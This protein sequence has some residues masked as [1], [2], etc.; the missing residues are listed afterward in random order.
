MKIT[1]LAAARDD[2]IDGFRFYEEGEEGLGSYFLSTLYADIESLRSLGGVHRK[3][4]KNYHRAFS[5]RFPF[6]IYYLLDGDSILVKAVIDCRR[7]P[8]WIRGHLRRAED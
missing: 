7:D 5:A 2:L 6:A 3:V 8:S 4:Y 1:V